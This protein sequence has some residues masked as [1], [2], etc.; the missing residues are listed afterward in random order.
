MKEYLNNLQRDELAKLHPDAN[1]VS[2]IDRVSKV[3]IT[4]N[5]DWGLLKQFHDY[6]VEAV[7]VMKDK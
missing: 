6:G 1:K 4:K 2:F 5:T 3:T 7:V